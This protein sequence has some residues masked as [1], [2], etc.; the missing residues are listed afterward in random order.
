MAVCVDDAEEAITNALVAARTLSGVNG[1]TV[2]V[3]PHDRL[4]CLT[5]QARKSRTDDG[6][7]PAG[8]H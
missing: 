2:N 3:L 4:R 5:K 7:R 6:I 1:F 8:L